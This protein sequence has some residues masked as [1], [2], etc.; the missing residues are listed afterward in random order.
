MNG[1]P[2]PA[3]ELADA[4]GRGVWGTFTVHLRAGEVTH[5]VLR[6][7]FQPSSD[8]RLSSQVQQHPLAK[9]AL[10][11]RLD[12][13]MVYARLRGGKLTL[14]AVEKHRMGT[15]TNGERKDD[16]SERS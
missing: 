16:H 10:T 4:Q 13:E 9:E 3:D 5:T 2:A 1:S 12:R 7:T 14:L 15:P 11:E 8:P 6:E